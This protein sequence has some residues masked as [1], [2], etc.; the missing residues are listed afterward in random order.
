VESVREIVLVSRNALRQ[1][2]DEIEYHVGIYWPEEAAFRR[3][4]GSRAGIGLGLS[5][6]TETSR[7]QTSHRGSIGRIDHRR[8]AREFSN[9][10]NRWTP[11]F[12]L[13]PK[14]V[15]CELIQPFRGVSVCEWKG[16][17][18]YW[19][20][21]IP[22]PTHQAV[23]WSYPTAQPPYERIADYFSF[24][25]GRVECFVD[26]QRVRPQPGYVYGG[27]VT[28]EIVGP[29]KGIAGTESW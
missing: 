14:D 19:T 26:D 21:I 9:S 3:R 7:R 8:L 6:S 12:Y 2:A 29:W 1:R 27:W 23:G 13:P 4:A 28:D 5:P 24:Y 22:A 15:R 16:T 18:K 17:A 20:L 10:R 11:T 25:P